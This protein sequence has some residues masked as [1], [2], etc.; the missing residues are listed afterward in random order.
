MLVNLNTCF[1]SQV[2]ITSINIL[3]YRD[4]QFSVINK[5]SMFIKRKIHTILQT[6]AGS[7][8]RG[9]T[10]SLAVALLYSE[11]SIQ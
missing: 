3:N 2:I 11:N 5:T 10:Q 8:S 6:D 9:V 7:V 4:V 1:I